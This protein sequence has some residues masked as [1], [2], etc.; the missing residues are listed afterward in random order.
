MKLMLLCE[1][2]LCLLQSVM[3]ELKVHLLESMLV[4]CVHGEVEGALT[5]LF[6]LLSM[7]LCLL[8]EISYSV[9]SRHCFID[10]WII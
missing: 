5:G 8:T 6:G 10:Q 3:K 1:T 2:L 7:F 9:L 4:E